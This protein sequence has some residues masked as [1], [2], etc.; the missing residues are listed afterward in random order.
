MMWAATPI[1]EDV[2]NRVTERSGIR[3]LHAYGATEVPGPALQSG[4]LPRPVAARH[5][6]AAGVRPR[7]AHGR[8]R[9]PR[10]RAA[11]Q[12]RRDHRARPAHDGGVPAGRGRRRRVPR[13]LG[14]HRRRR[15]GGARGLDPHHRPG[16][17]DDQGLGVLGGAGRDRGDAARP[18]RGRRLRRV[19]RAARDEGRGAQGGGRAHR[20]RCRDRRR[21]ARVRRRA[22]RRLQARG[23]LR[24]RRRHPA[25]GVGQGPAPHAEGRRRRRSGAAR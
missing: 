10:G 12:R 19:R 4:R 20:A 13:R 1:A 22:A 18:S 2:A 16:Q 7:G 5:A 3:W 15:L 6:R 9:D 17:G 21:P 14:A 25:H 23:G 11:R 8:P 24:V